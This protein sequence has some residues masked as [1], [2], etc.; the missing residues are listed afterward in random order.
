MSTLPPI[1]RTPP[2]RA[3]P[4]SSARARRLSRTCA[5]VRDAGVDTLTDRCM[6][7]DVEAHEPPRR[8]WVHFVQSDF[9]LYLANQQMRHTALQSV[10][11]AA[12][13][14]N[15]RFCEFTELVNSPTFDA[16]L[17]MARRFG[18]PSCFLTIAPDDVH[19]PAIVWA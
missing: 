5:C 6:P 7:E 2:H 19:D 10:S 12:K 8:G 4:A 3:A 18:P 11:R 15:D 9:V 16:E 1:A 17:A 13:V 14:R